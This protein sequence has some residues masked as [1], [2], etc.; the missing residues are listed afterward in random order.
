[1]LVL[2]LLQALGLEDSH[3]KISGAFSIYIYIIICNRPV[4]RFG[5]V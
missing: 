1:M 2:L 5:S 3:V 4:P